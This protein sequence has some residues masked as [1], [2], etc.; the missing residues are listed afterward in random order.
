MIVKPH[1]SNCKRMKWEEKINKKKI[2]NKAP[3]KP[4]EV[5]KTCE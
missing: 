1:D 3:A 2:K 4:S 5:V